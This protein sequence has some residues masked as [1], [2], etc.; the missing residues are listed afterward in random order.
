MNKE[1][2]LKNVLEELQDAVVYPKV[3][4]PTMDGTDEEEMAND[5]Y[6]E[7]DKCKILL[8][9][10]KNLEQENKQLKERIDKAIINIRRKEPKEVILEILK[11]DNNE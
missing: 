9:Y 11:G 2:K 6:L 8:D 7:V 3:W 4:F 1:E 5:K 10:I